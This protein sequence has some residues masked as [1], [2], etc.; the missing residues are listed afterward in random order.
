MKLTFEALNLPPILDTASNTQQVHKLGPNQSKIT[1][2][3][4][5]GLKGIFKIV[6]PVLK[7][8]FQNTIGGV[9]NE[10]KLHAEAG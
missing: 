4:N 5:L 8:R 10:L 1:F 7:R 3:M 2:D 9:Q 6:G